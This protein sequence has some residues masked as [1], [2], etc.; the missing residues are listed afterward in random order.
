MPGVGW[1]PLESTPGG[2][3]PVMY[4]QGTA[5]ATESTVLQ[6][7]PAPEE[8]TPEPEES[9]AAVEDDLEVD[10]RQQNAE[11]TPEDESALDWLQTYWQ[12]A[13]I[14]A[15]AVLILLLWLGNYLWRWIWRRRFSNP[16]PNRAALYLYVFIEKLCRFGCDMP[17]EAERIA[18]KAQFSAHKIEENELER[19]RDGLEGCKKD[20]RK[21]QPAWKVRL[22]KLWGFIN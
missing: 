17:Q 3:S 9:E 14:L 10:Q 13:I 1:V 6:P 5:A 18:M 8:T 4:G 12:I 22:M 11:E 20:L 21:S 19:M 15:V 16:D 7:T 2:A